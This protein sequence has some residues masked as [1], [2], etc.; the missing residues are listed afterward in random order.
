M[1]SWENRVLSAGF[2]RLQCST[3]TFIRLRAQAALREK[4]LFP[5]QHLP[6]PDG[7]DHSA[8]LEFKVLVSSGRDPQKQ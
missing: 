3:M 6:V 8:R 2:V 1:A 7:A 5:S 4:I